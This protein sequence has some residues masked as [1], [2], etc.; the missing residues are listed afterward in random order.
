MAKRKFQDKVANIA[1]WV[2]II[3]YHWARLKGELHND[4]E[5]W[6]DT[7][8]AMQ[9]EDWWDIV[10]AYPTM[11]D[12]HED[13]FRQHGGM[14]RDVQIIEQRLMFGKPVVKTGRKDHNF[15]PFRALM[16]LKDVVNDINETPTLKFDKVVDEE[17]TQFQKLFDL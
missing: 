17:P 4:H 1:D 11:Y 6:D 5:F 10:E 15:A 14:A 13:L 9:P 2:E 16:V 8:H 12:L 7:L 3:N